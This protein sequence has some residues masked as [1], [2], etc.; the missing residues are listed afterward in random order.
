M[1]RSL[2][3]PRGKTASDVSS[4]TQILEELVR[5]YQEHTDKKYDNDLKLQGV[6][7]IQPKQIEQQLLLEDRNGSATYES[8]KRILN[9]WILMNSTGRADMDLETLENGRRRRWRTRRRLDG[10]VQWILLPEWTVVAHGKELRVNGDSVLQLLT[11]AR[12]KG[13]GKQW[14]G[15][16]KGENKEKR[17]DKIRKGWGWSEKGK[18]KGKGLQSVNK[19]AEWDLTDEFTSVPILSVSYG[20]TGKNRVAR[21]EDD[22]RGVANSMKRVESTCITTTAGN[23]KFAWDNQFESKVVTRGQNKAEA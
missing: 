5:K 10:T 22:A 6:Y 11:T 21:P 7:D 1:K 12:K 16:G 15:E 4:A 2:E 20:E 3:I 8:V 13:R 9:N 17:K 18:G 19:W 23:R 14:K